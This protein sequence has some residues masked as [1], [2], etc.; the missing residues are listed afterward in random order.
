MHKESYSNCVVASQKAKQYGNQGSHEFRLTASL[1]HSVFGTDVTRGKLSRNHPS[2][3]NYVR[4]YNDIVSGKIEPCD[5]IP[6]LPSNHNAYS[7][8][9]IFS[10]IR[11]WSK[12][13]HKD[14]ILVVS[15]GVLNQKPK[16]LVNQ[17]LN[18]L[19][20]ENTTSIPN[21]VYDV[22]Y[23]GV[24]YMT[25]K[26][27]KATMLLDENGWW[28]SYLP[29]DHAKHIHREHP[30]TNTQS[31]N[32]NQIYIDSLIRKIAEKW[33]LYDDSVILKPAT[34]RAAKIIRNE[35]KIVKMLKYTKKFHSN[36]I[37]LQGV[38]EFAELL[39]DFD[40]IKELRLI[41][42]TLGIRCVY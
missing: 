30:L 1:R 31:Q 16:L 32:D 20:M 8:S 36:T 13:F 41:E 39:L 10:H 22:M 5:F 23:S 17:I 4:L 25:L 6:F 28:K 19:G 14:N 37:T 11:W 26:Q 29:Q 7:R 12:F 42:E 9:H 24:R 18:F 35:M 33:A 27:S 15:S 3:R 40:Y 2:Y 34:S 21:Y 38:T